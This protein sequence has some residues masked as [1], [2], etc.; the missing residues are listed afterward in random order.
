MGRIIRGRLG[1]GD[2]FPG[3]RLENKREKIE[4]HVFYAERLEEYWN[5][6]DSFEGAAY[7]RIKTEIIVEEEQE[8]VEAFIYALK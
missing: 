4:G 5:E 1:F 2:G 6:L 3:I 8:K 7:Q